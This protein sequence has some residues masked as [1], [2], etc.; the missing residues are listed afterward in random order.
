MYT[1][2]FVYTCVIYAYL[3]VRIS[4]HFIAKIEEKRRVQT[5]SADLQFWES[6]T[7]ISVFVALL[8]ESLSHLIDRTMLLKRVFS[9]QVYE[10]TNGDDVPSFNDIPV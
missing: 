5:Q 8:Y 7:E 6:R 1:C 2:A 3:H 4:M 10:L 9:V